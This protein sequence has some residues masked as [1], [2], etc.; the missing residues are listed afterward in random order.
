MIIFMHCCVCNLLSLSNVALHPLFCVINI[1]AVRFMW[2]LIWEILQTFTK[3]F[4]HNVSIRT[5]INHG[6]LAKNGKVYG[7]I[8]ISQTRWKC[9]EI[10]FCMWYIWVS[11]FN[12][13]PVCTRLNIL[14]FLLYC[15]RD[16]LLGLDEPGWIELQARILST[17]AQGE[18]RAFI[19]LRLT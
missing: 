16:Y 11:L 14:T 15:H 13:L 8:N 7:W 5:R 4:L 9:T 12:V 1:Q 10:H 19:S 2:V 3:I 18:I 6:D 17:W